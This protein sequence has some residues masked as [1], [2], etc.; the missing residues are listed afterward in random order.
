M[1]FVLIPIV[2]LIVIALCWA[3]CRMA[4][5]GDAGLEASASQAISATGDALAGR[6]DLPNLSH[7]EPRLTAHGVR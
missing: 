4:Q 1:L 6:E 5:R 7:Q 2:W 3:A